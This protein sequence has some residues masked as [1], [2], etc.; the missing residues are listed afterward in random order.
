MAYRDPVFIDADPTTLLP[1][2]SGQEMR[3]ANEAIQAGVFGAG[4]LKVTASSGM[5]LSVAAGLGAVQGNVGGVWLPGKYLCGLDAAVL[6]SAI[7]RSDGS[8]QGFAANA[9]AFPRLDQLIARVWDH[10]LDGSGL[11]RWLLQIVQGVA[12]SG[13]TLANRSGAV[14]D[15]ALPANVLRLADVLVPGGNPTSI[16]SG[17]IQDRR[18]SARGLFAN[19]TPTTN[20]PTVGTGVLTLAEMTV[21]G[22]FS[23][24]PVEIAW[25][26]TAQCASACSVDLFLQLDGAPLEDLQIT[27]RSTELPAGNLTR[28]VSSVDT[29]DVSA[30]RHTVELKWSSSLASPNANNVTK[31]R[32]FVVREVLSRTLT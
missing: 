16:P 22:E 32:S 29:H 31:R 7:D 26:M 15:G 12:T 30:G 20:A 3:W 25:S 19:P 5:V 23:G 1:A 18:P 11:R 4:D 2:M 9:S 14:A 13:A 6:S 28:T 17:N 10:S 8:G 24:A 27:T 21:T